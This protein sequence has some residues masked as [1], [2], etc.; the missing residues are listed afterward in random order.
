[1]IEMIS[2]A[3]HNDIAVAFLFFYWHDINLKIKNLLTLL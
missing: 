3:C 1:M 2:G